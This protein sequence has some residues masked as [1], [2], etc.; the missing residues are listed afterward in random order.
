VVGCGNGV[1]ES[2]E[3][4]DD[5]DLTQC[6]DTQECHNCQCVYVVEADACGD[7]FCNT[8][9]ENTDLCP[10]DCTCVDNGTCEPGE[11]FNCADCGNPAEACGSPC[12]SSET[13]PSPLSCFNSVC[14]EACL[15]GG[16]CGEGGEGEEG[17][18]CWCVGP[19]R[20]CSDGT[21]LYGACEP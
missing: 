15:C 5:P 18:E 8:T 11:G 9:T 12:E 4:C 7:G 6:L 14:W 1:V 19:D 16:N 20:E 2:G 10:E 3:Q 17:V 13:C 21:W